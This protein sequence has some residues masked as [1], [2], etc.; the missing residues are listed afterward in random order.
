ML[1]INIP[2]GFKE[3]R[4]YIIEV[5]LGEFLGLEFEIKVKSGISA[6]SI[7]LENENV[8]E[9][10]DA[11]F[12]KIFL[13]NEKYLDI[14][15][16]PAEVIICDLEGAPENNIIGIYGTP[17]IIIGGNRIY[18]GVDL[19]ASAFF[20]LTRWEEFVN[21]DKDIHGRFPAKASLAGRHGFLSRPVVNEYIEVIWHWLEKLR[22][23]QKRRVRDFRM[24]STHDIDRIRLFQAKLD[25]I[26][27]PIKAFL[28]EKDVAALIYHSRLALRSLGGND[29]YFVFDYLMDVSEQHDLRSHF[30]FMTS[31]KT[32]FDDGYDI[33]AKA[34]RD[35]IEQI[36]DRG[37]T[38]GIHP[39]Y[40]TVDNPELLSYEINRLREI[41][42]VEI[43]CGRQHYLRFKVPD[44][45][46]L[47]DD[48]GMQW[49]STLVHPEQ[50]G[51]RCGVCYPYP[52]FNIL[53][54]KKL[55]LREKPLTI[56]DGSLVV[57]QKQHPDEAGTVI[58]YYLNKV[59][60]YS[61][62]FVFLWHNSSFDYLVWK[63]YR[64][65]FERTYQSVNRRKRD[66]SADSIVDI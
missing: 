6:T 56:M 61:G 35:V 28:M 14:Q 19:F 13:D 65:I 7:C 18:C 44:T 16:V 20:M 9:I 3:E 30:F 31:E 55:T 49:D 58:D 50:P 11:F 36:I 62:E 22:I 15:N 42:G 24:V 59:K 33:E 5:M 57:Y 2:D 34:V 8:L 27:K 46:Q 26:G 41:T 43:N 38:I 52:A 10:N 4:T 51:F 32:K 47:W 25:Y 48:N 54:R 37:H 66:T 53:S 64:H 60:Q 12:R 17:E 40:N 63:D 1:I 45:W 29:P 21:E 23:N 39:S